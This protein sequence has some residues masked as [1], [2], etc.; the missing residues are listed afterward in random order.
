MLDIL[1]G[2]QWG[3]EGK[4]KIVD[5]I[6]NSYDIIARFQGGP[7]A[8]HTISFNGKKYVLHTIPSGIFRDKINI[9]GNGVVIDPVT[10]KKEIEYLEENKIDVRNNLFVSRKACLILPTHILLDKNYER[11]KGEKKI[12]STLRGIQPSYVDKIGRVS[13]RVGDIEDENFNNK[14]EYLYNKHLEILS[15]YNFD[16]QECQK[17]KDT[18]LKSLDLLKKLNIID[19]EVFINKK[20][21]NNLKVL[22][23]GA[24]GSLLDIDFGTYPYV[25]SSNTISSS[26]CIGLG[27]SPKKINDVIGILKAYVTRVGNGPLP[28]EMEP[29]IEEQVSK[30][31]KEFGATTGR[32][33]KC[34]W[35]DIPALKYSTQINGITELA[36][37]KVDVLKDLDKIK[38][39]TKYKYKGKEIDY[40]PFDYEKVTPIYKEFKGWKKEITSLKDMNENIYNYL[41][42]IESELQVPIKTI[43]VGPQRE[44]T[45][46]F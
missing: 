44:Q 35:L 30:I 36:I 29:D 41:R 12:G 18:W 16:A 11:E 14:F 22:A 1:V 20:M 5:R 19:S 17:M 39:C 24:Q 34:G 8:G 10:L 25:T 2:L 28:T 45:F 46:N 42:F 15:K 26:A 38:V 23:E 4:G 31:G 7:N 32:K 6:C 9:I 27:V 13:I 43:S 37:T 21:N 40:I 33:R 3:D